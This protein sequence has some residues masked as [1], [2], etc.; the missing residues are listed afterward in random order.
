MSVQ[1]PFFNFWVLQDHDGLS[2][3]DN[4]SNVSYDGLQSVLFDLESRAY[5]RLTDQEVPHASAASTIS[6][7]VVD[8]QV[9]NERNSHRS[10]KLTT[11]ATSQVTVVDKVLGT[12]WD[13]LQRFAVSWTVTKDMVSSSSVPTSGLYVVVGENR[14]HNPSNFKRDIYTVSA[15]QTLTRYEDDPETG[16]RVTVAESVV[17]HGTSVPTSTTTVFYEQRQ[18]DAERD[19]LTTITLPSAFDRTTYQTIQFTWPALLAVWDGTSNPTAAVAADI[20]TGSTVEDATGRTVFYLS[21]PLRESFTEL[22]EVRVREQIISASA[23]ATLL[24]ATDNPASFGDAES[25]GTDSLRAV[26]WN[27]R[28]RDF[29]YDGLMVELRISNVLTDTIALTFSAASGDTYYG[30]GFSESFTITRSNISATEYIAVIGSLV[31]IEDQIEP[32]KYGLY[33]RRRT[34]VVVK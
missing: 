11:V 5:V 4:S 24:A 32:W 22:T 16:K 9:K 1:L 29:S 14:E 31:C 18:V 21:T 33:K 28:P 15:W 13:Q 2:I 10:R 12:A 19:I 34:S 3:S 17:A 7:G 25:L 27:P 23:A 8:A 26:L 20:A 30:Y 6:Y